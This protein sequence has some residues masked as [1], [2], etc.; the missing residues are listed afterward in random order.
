MANSIDFRADQVQTSKIIVTGST[1]Q[2]TLL[3]YGID[4]QDTPLNQGNIDPAKFDTTVVGTDVFLFVS[5]GIGARGGT[6][7]WITAIGGDLHISG[8]LTVDGTSPGGSGGNNFFFSNTLDVIETSG[9]IKL[10]GSLPLQTTYLSASVGVEITGSFVQG[11]A[12]T[13]SGD[14]SHAQGNGTTASGT[15]AHAE[16]DGSTASGPNS[17]AEG[18]QTTASADQTHAEGY[19]TTASSPNSH[20][21]GAGTTASGKKAHAEGEGSVASGDVSHAEGYYS[22]ASGYSSHA[23]GYYSF[24]LGEY[25]HAK[26]YG[27]EAFGTGSLAVG[28][29]TVASGA[30]DG[31]SPPTTTQAAFGKYNLRD[32]A[33]SL[34]VVGDGLDDLNRHDVLRVNSGSVQITGSLFVNGTQITSSIQKINIAGYNRTNYTSPTVIGLAYFDP[35]EYTT[36]SNIAFTA[37]GMNMAGVSGG[38]DLYNQNTS[39]LVAQLTW[40]GATSLTTGSFQTATFSKPITATSYELH[41]SQSG[42]A[43][44]GT[45]YSTV[46]FV[47]F[48]LS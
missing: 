26:G 11:A 48:V 40:S 47:N 6:D 37:V 4:A 17:H 34:F 42:G 15:N 3:I 7:P 25:S 45:D 5:G 46:G 13:A 44:G 39:T 12:T 23:E 35:S 29:Y 2:K 30:V 20:A 16:G 41:F 31:A 21:E 18:Y 19:Q 38:L 8:N 28:L 10:S 24:A 22:T 9:S 43:N 33:D 1:P 27:S 36:F 32:N 14:Y